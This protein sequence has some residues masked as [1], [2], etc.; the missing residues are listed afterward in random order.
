MIVKWIEAMKNGNVLSDFG[1]RIKALR[2]QKRW[3]QKELAQKI[4]VQFQQLNKYEGGLHAPPID[5]LLLLA[6]ALGTTIDFL[7]SG[8]QSEIAPL[9]NRRLLERLQAMEKFE[10]EDQEMLIRLIDAMIVKN[11]A[12]GL[13]SLPQ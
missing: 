10:N 7:L 3:S 2:K 12:Q 13:L 11:R 8:N 4:G 6:D 9:Q 1:K 5:K